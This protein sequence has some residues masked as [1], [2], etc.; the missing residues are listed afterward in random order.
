MSTDFKQKGAKFTGT[1]YDVTVSVGFDN[2]DLGIDE[3]FDG[4]V[5][6]LKGLGW[7]DLTINQYIKELA[8]EY[9]EDEADKEDTQA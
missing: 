9:K 2:N 8:E 7:Q 5:T 6:I 3:V 4:F 1:S